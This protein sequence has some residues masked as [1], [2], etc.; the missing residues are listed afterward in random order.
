MTRRPARTLLTARD[1]EILAA[2]DRCPLTVEQLL[3]ISRTFAEPFCSESRVRGRLQALRRAG[4]VRRWRYATASRGTAPDYYRLTL[5]GYRL[6]YGADAQRV[7]KRQFSEIGVA[8]QRHT[9]A[10]AD[11]I[12]HTLVSAHVRGLA[13]V[14]FCRENTLRLE[15]GGE[16]L[17]PD[18]AFAIRLADQQFNFVVEL[19]N[20]TER[21]RSQRD[22]DSWERKLRLYEAYQDQA[23][24]RLRVLIVSTRSHERADYI[25]RT[26]AALAHNPQRMLAYSVHLD[27]YFAEPDA[28]CAACFTDHCGRQVAMLPLPPRTAT[29]EKAGLALA[30]GGGA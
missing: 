14:D 24:T 22:A 1:E 19:D 4:W 20:G 12:T 30:R 5:A 27:A 9:R 3:K 6:L 21:V 15:V 26:A 11:F 23:S 18:S 7:T 10:L 25:R 8:R 16:A 29:R 2:I 13:V 17:F 28:L